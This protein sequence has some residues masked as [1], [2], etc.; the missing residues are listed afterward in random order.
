[1]KCDFIHGSQ[2][3]TNACA[4]TITR[5]KTALMKLFSVLTL[6]A[7]TLI[8][9]DFSSEA[10]LQVYSLRGMIKKGDNAS[11]EAML[12]KTK[13]FG[14]K[15]IELAGGWYDLSAADL[16]K[17]L[18]DRSITPISSHFSYERFDKELPKVIDE[19]KS[20]GL[21]YAGIAW[22]PHVPAMFGEE[23]TRK[24]VADFN[25][26]GEE[27]SKNG[28]QFF[29]H[30]HGYEFKPMHEGGQKTFMDLLVEETNPKFVTFE[31]DV[32]WV[33][34]PGADPVKYLEKYPGR[35]QLMHIKDLQKGIR[36]GIYTGH[37]PNEQN[38]VIGTGQ[39]KWPEIFR[40]ASK[41]GVKEYFIED[42]HPNAGEQIPL[43]M[44]YLDSLK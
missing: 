36:T 23:T 11:V 13:S 27:L 7:S 9:G 33:V 14:I 40:A 26:W 17:M 31:M 16:K 32:F 2:R 42:E 37:A 41:A 5:Q 6:T 1:M 25:K 29:Y 30:C 4:F 24:A 18:S 44:K 39:M 35:W 12:D 38:V 8:A 28:I 22:I 19:A 3:I 15:K 10:G 34:H 21:K 43:S 20:M